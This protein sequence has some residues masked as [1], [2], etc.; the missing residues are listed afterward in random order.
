MCP[1]D[2]FLILVVIGLCMVYG[3]DFNN[4]LSL[5]TSDF[6]QSCDCD[7]SSLLSSINPMEL[8]LVFD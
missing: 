7:F 5:G 4:M 1:I 6:I 8:A 2:W 3:I